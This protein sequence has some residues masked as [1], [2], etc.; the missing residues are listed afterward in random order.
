MKLL[1]HWP[2]ALYVFYLCLMAPAVLACDAILDLKSS[3]GLVER[4][5]LGDPNEYVQRV[6][7]GAAVSFST[8]VFP[9]QEMPNKKKL[10]RDTVQNMVSTVASRNKNSKPQA[11]VLNEELLPQLDTRLA[12]LTYIQYGREGSMNVEAAGLIKN[13]SCWSIVRFTALKKQ[14]RDEG[15]NQFA[16]LIRSTILD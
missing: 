2:A 13:E 7:S 10:L 3:P 14:T 15:L 11:Q 16:N 5:M 8:L 9:S 4:G 12:F 1:K 6:Y